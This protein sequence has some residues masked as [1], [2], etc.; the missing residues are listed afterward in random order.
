[1]KG[2][3]TDLTR[4][5]L[6]NIFILFGLVTLLCTFPFRNVWAVGWNV[7]NFT[8]CTNYTAPFNT[9]A[10]CDGSAT[11]RYTNVME[12]LILVNPHKT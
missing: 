11:C 2:F 12:V 7:F 9:R 3:Q 1:M 10:R 6:I 5:T 4:R 8:G